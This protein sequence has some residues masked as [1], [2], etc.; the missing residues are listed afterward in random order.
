[1]NKVNYVFFIGAI[2][3]I[4]LLPIANKFQYIKVDKGMIVKTDPVTG[5][6]QRCMV[7]YEDSGVQL[8]CGN[9]LDNRSEIY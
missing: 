6:S 4:G 1:M 8:D 3:I 7:L 2:F 9:N 5:E